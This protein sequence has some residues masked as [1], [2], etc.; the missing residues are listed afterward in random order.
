M[1]LRVVFNVFAGDGEGLTI[2]HVAGGAENS[3]AN[4]RLCETNNKTS[5]NCGGVIVWFVRAGFCKIV[6]IPQ[7]RTD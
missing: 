5:A 7:L 2:C 3:V 4:T 6:S 1:L